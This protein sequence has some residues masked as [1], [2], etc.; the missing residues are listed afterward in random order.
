MMLPPTPLKDF[1]KIYSMRSQEY[2]EACQTYFLYNLELMKSF[3]C[4]KTFIQ[5]KEDELQI[6]GK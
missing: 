1:R 2:H 5:G 3:N 6:K 4:S